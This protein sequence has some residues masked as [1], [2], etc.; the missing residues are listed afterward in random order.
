M[1][2][3]TLAVR[4]MAVVVM[5]GMILTGAA[6]SRAAEREEDYTKKDVKQMATII[7]CEAGNQTYAGKLAVGVVV[8]NRKRSSLYP[9]SVEKV[10][11]QR[12]QF[13]PVASGKWKAELKRYKEGKYESGVRAQCV[14]AAKEALEG[15]TEVTYKGEDI[16]MKKYC[17]FSQHLSGAKLRIGG[18]DFK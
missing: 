8:M 14:K 17:F 12:G 10:I 18:H 5:V 1:N 6:T 11:T 3:K 16:N 9:N 2:F 4:M 7:F 13:S 15:A